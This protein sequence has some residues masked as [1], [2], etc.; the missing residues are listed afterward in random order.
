MIYVI[1]NYEKFPHNALTK[2]NAPIEKSPKFYY[3]DDVKKP[4]VNKR[5]SKPTTLI[6]LIYLWFQ[7]SIL[8][9]MSK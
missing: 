2:A 8:I 7:K 1:L 6:F 5:K 4:L 9:Q 3:A